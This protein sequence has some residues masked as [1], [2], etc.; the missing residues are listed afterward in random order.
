MLQI[1]T[2]PPAIESRNESAFVL[3][4]SGQVP[5]SVTVAAQLEVSEAIPESFLS[6]WADYQAGRVV[7][8]DKALGDEPPPPA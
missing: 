8:M 4:V 2:P 7:D 6:G 1:S 3:H 5:Q